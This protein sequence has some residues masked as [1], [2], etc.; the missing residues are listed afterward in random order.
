MSRTDL[1]LAGGLIDLE[2]AI[3]RWFRRARKFLELA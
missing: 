2:D 3:R 1:A